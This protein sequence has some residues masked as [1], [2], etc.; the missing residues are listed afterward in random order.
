M[1]YYLEKSTKN[2]TFTDSKNI[3]LHFT[4]GTQTKP[5]FVRPDK[6]HRTIAKPAGNTITLKCASAG[7]PTPNISWYK[8]GKEPSRSLGDIK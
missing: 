1:A 6:M 2:L 3:F 8:N 5:R 4:D 7:N